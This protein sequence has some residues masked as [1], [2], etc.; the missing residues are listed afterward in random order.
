MEHTLF[1]PTKKSLVPRS[2]KSYHNS[3]SSLSRI[4]TDHFNTSYDILIFKIPIHITG[5][6]FKYSIKEKSKSIHSG[7][8]FGIL[9]CNLGGSN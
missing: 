9:K 1:L 8:E 7:P 6:M 4:V 2:P 3:E 5:M